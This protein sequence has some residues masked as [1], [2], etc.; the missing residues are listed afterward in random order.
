MVILLLDGPIRKLNTWQ[1]RQKF[2]F[3]CINDRNFFRIP[4]QM[5]PERQGL[6][7][8]CG[9]VSNLIRAGHELAVV[10]MSVRTSLYSAKQG[11][12]RALRRQQ[13]RADDRSLTAALHDRG[14]GRKISLFGPTPD[15]PGIAPIQS[16]YHERR[17]FFVLSHMM[18]FRKI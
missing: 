14:N 17:S 11:Q 9:T 2:C 15:E 16:Q 6:N 1:A 18:I 4:T 10:I 3:E 7:I 12:P 13:L 5:R 8:L